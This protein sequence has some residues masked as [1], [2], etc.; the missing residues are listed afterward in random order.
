MSDLVIEFADELAP[1]T[2]KQVEAA[3]AGLVPAVVENLREHRKINRARLIEYFLNGAAPSSIDFKRARQN[4]N[5]LK[6]VYAGTQWLTAAEIGAQLGEL[7]GK[8]PANP[9]AQASRWKTL[10]DVFAIEHDGKD[11]YPRY[12]FGID[13]RPLPVLKDIIATFAPTDPMRLAAWFESTSAFLGG[14]RPR[15][16]IAE[17]GVKVLEAVQDLRLQQAR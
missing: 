7:T 10:G 5:A 4:A 2:K 6:A 17:D 15:E 8:K 13:W 11:R 3:L 9:S 16:V 1:G 12:A 14:R